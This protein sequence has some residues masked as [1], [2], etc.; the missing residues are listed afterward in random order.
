MQKAPKESKHS[1]LLS[2]LASFPFPLSPP[3]ISSGLNIGAPVQ[4]LSHQTV[5]PVTRVFK[6]SLAIYTHRLQLQALS[7]V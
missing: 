2:L 1:L 3:I 5:V 6:K 4:A 7:Q